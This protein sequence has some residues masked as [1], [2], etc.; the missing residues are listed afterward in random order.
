MV[1]YG[2]DLTNNAKRNTS[3]E[4]DPLA[5]APVALRVFPFGGSVIEKYI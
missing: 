3:L 4:N 2:F 1:F 5:V